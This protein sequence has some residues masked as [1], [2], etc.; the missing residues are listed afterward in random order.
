MT[1]F[2]TFDDTHL[3]LLFSVLVW[4]HPLMDVCHILLDLVSV[5]QITLASCVPHSDSTWLFIIHSSRL[6][7]TVKYEH[8]F[9]F[10][11]LS[12][13][14]IPHISLLVTVDLIEKTMVRWM[15]LLGEMCCPLFHGVF[16]KLFYFGVDVIYFHHLQYP[17]KRYEV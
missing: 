7:I 3:T 17:A 10:G 15:Y 6:E 11:P 16:E 13:N 9:F 12:Q 8:E 4:T 14:H 5:L 2:S 1:L